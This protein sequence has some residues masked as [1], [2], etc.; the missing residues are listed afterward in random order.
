MRYKYICKWLV[1]LF[2]CGVLSYPALAQTKEA[3]LTSPDGQIEINF[4]IQDEPEAEV[5]VK[6]GQLVYTVTFQDENLITPSELTLHLEGEEPL[7]SNVHISGINITEN[8][9]DKYQL[10]TGRTSSVDDRYNLLTLDLEEK[11]GL[12]RKFTVQVRAYNDGVAFRY[13]IPE[14]PNLSNI[15]LT[16]ERTAFRLSNDATAYAMVL[17]HYESMYESEFYKL[18]LSAFSNQGGV[19]SEMLIGLPLLMEVPGTGW[20]AVTDADLEDYAAAYVTN[21]SG[22]WTGHMVETRLSPQLENPDIAVTGSLPFKTSWKVIMV[23]DNPGTFIESTLVTNL[24]PPSKIKD[25]SWIRGGKATWNWWSG[26]LDKNE[27]PAFTTEN[28]K[29]Y[30]DFAAES[31]F[32]Y[33]LIDAGWSEG[34]NITKMNGRVDIPAVVEYAEKKDVKVWIWTAYTQVLEQMDEA[35]PLFEKWGVAGTKIDFVERDDQE[36]IKFYYD[37][38]KKA[39]EHNLMVDIHGSTKPTGIERT[40]PNVMGYEGVLGMEQ[41][42]AGRRDNPSHHVMLPFTRMLVSLMDYT[43]GGFDNVTREEFIPRMRDPMVMGTRAHHLAM[44]VIYDVPFQMVSD[45]PTAYRGEPAFEFIKNVP[46]VWD[47]TVFLNGEP[48]NYVTLAR[49]QGK[50]WYLGSMTDWTE[51]DIEIPLSFLGDG[52][53]KAVIYKDHAEANKNPKKVTIEEQ[54]V[55]AGT[56]L[57]IN[58]AKGGGLAVEFLPDD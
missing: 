30:V 31:G 48:G 53:F 46:T 37:V 23:A 51:R 50:K 4:T 24:N 22:S 56:V 47:E 54:T 25:T 5:P 2:L 38:A 52:N 16:D 11:D 35:F 20:L 13:E 36:G 14:Q 43:P 44:Y 58:L 26:S 8:H 10:I 49:K 12:K 21:S 28:M 1:Y 29:Y 18:P 9:T 7:G 19:S 33:M 57:N 17:P 32:K 42:K 6:R 41:S 40:W 39:A 27:E 15:R 3:S 34:N 45:H 55:T